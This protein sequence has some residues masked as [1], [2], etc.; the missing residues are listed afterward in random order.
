[1]IVGSF[2]ASGNFFLRIICFDILGLSADMSY[3]IAYCTFMTVAFFAYKKFIFVLTDLPIQKQ[4]IR[5][6]LVNLMMLP[7]TFNLFFWL[8]N[9]FNNYN[10]GYY[11]ELLAH[12]IALAAPPLITFTLH[13]LVS[14]KNVVEYKKIIGKDLNR[15]F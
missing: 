6:I 11:S 2:C 14:F 9:I 13:R 5:F 3:I 10:F 12:L 8:A 15:K 4:G 1:V 7:I